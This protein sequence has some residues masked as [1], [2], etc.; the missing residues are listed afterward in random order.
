MAILIG[1]L[2][3]FRIEAPGQATRALLSRDY[4][5]L[6]AYLM[7]HGR[8]AVPR[9][10]AARALWPARS[11]ER[12]DYRLS[13]CISQARAVLV[14]LGSSDDVV[15][16]RGGVI[17]VHAEVSTDLDML[18]QAEVRVHGAVRLEDANAALAEMRDLVGRGLLPLLEEPWVDEH[19]AKIEERIERAREYSG[20]LAV[21]LVPA[22]LDVVLPEWVGTLREAASS[23]GRDPLS[24]S[25]DDL[26]V[27]A[28]AEDERHLLAIARVAER[29]MAGKS[30][31]VMIHLLD[32]YRE[33]MDRAVERALSRRDRRVAQGFCAALWQYWFVRRRVQARTFVEQAL[34]L[35]SR[36]LLTTDRATCL[37][38]SGV[39]A[40]LDGDLDAASKR[41][42]EA[43]E[44]W[45]QLGDDSRLAR[46]V[47]ARARLARTAGEYAEAERLTRASLGMHR[48]LGDVP[49]AAKRLR[50]LAKIGLAMGDHDLARASAREAAELAEAFADTQAAAKARVT[51]GLLAAVERR[52]DAADSEYTSALEAAGESGDV[53]LASVALRGL[54]VVSQLRWH[55]HGQ[56]GAWLTAALSMYDRATALARESQD[57]G[58]VADCL[59]MKSDALAEAGRGVEAISTCR[60][61][62]MLAESAGDS[63]AAGKA[64]EQLDLL[65][66]H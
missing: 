53:V 57:L 50:E 41:L 61:A 51:L 26:S 45:G 64:R 20:E 58:A 23:A 14:E 43:Q 48:H 40:A 1:L 16:S 37:H 19:R 21:A 42:A 2:D 60:Q 63:F 36:P 7:L 56:Q 65:L 39:L 27:A 8:P 55:E 62:V 4:E 6:L 13:T 52:T 24:P 3:S 31:D 33:R 66:E 38:G 10:W 49:R 35:T 11:R 28:V 15:I 46:T 25:G 22:G 47:G 17:R 34:A 44:G 9:E 59:R 32:G 30:R 12:A 5:R 18:S 29:E 54:G